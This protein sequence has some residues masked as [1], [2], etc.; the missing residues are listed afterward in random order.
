LVSWTGERKLKETQYQKDAKR[1][2]IKKHKI[3]WMIISKILFKSVDRQKT[4]NMNS[5]D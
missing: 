1:K 4:I 5:T 3:I 2:T